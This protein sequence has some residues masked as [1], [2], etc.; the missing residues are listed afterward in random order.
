MHFTNS[1]P[2]GGLHSV[3]TFSESVGTWEVEKLVLSG[4]DPEIKVPRSWIIRPR[5]AAQSV[6]VVTSPGGSSCRQVFGVFS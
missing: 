4:E 5:L 6:Q 2:F 3:A 1:L